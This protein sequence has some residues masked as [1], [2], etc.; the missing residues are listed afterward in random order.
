MKQQIIC[1][2]IL[3]ILIPGFMF[4]QKTYPL[5][6][7]SIPNSKPW[8]NEEETKSEENGTIIIGKISQPSVN[9]FLPSRETANG[10]AVV[11]CPGGGYWVVAENLEGTDL[12]KEFVKWGV[13]AIVVKYRIPNDQWMVNR[14]IGPLQDAQQAIKITRENAA[15]WGIDPNRVGI[16]GFSAGGHLA[17]TAGTHFKK[18]YIPNAKKTNLRPD[19]MILGYPVISFL[20][21]IGHMGSRDQLIG[22][23]PSQEKINEYSNELQVT[24]ETPPTFLVHAS[25]DDV[26]VPMN[27]IAFYDSLISKKVSAEIH[28]Y[29]SGGHGFGLQIKGTKEFWMDR[30]KNWMESMGWLKKK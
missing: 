10:A 3:A 17:S 5:Y 8:A 22:K 2:L 20:S 16:M 29:K 13:A 11:I 14:E 27:S 23:T 26:V 28:I 1:I 21:S 7:D 24:P 18:T 4:S 12:A 9:V 15:A 25:D 6:T 30:C 19:F